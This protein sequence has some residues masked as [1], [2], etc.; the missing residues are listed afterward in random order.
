M[1]LIL[2][3]LIFA[4]CGFPNNTEAQ[5]AIAT[6]KS[7]MV[8]ELNEQELIDIFSLEESHW[9]N[10][11]RIVPVELKGKSDIKS[12]FYALIGR[13]PN[14]IKRKRLRIVLAGDGDPPIPAKSAEEMLAKIS[15]TPG[16]I[17][18]LP[19]HL[20]SA[21]EVNVIHIIEN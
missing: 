14:E 5:I 12:Q 16:A 4:A 15:S 8:S 19:L 13:S 6:H 1:K 3:L 7:V 9:S 10:G 21:D 11:G 2:S 18:Y 20:A 17:G